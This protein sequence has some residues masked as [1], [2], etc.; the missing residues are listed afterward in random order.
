VVAGAATPA[1]ATGSVFY[2][3]A[4]GAIDSGANSCAPTSNPGADGCDLTAALTNAGSGDT[5]YLATPGSA[6]SYYGNWTVSGTSPLTIEALTPGSDQPIL[7]GDA[8]A[9]AT[10]QTAACDSSILSLAAGVDLTINSVE[11]TDSD[12]TATSMGGA[13]DNADGTLVVT[14]CTFDDNTSDS[15][16]GA[17]DNADNGGAGSLDVFGSTFNDNTADGDGGAIDNADYGGE[18]TAT[19]SDSTFTANTADGSDGGAI[20]NGDDNS[21]SGTLTVT[22][23]TFSGDNSN[24]SGAAIANGDFN[25]D[26]TAWVAGDVFNET[27]GQADVVAGTSVWNDEGYNSGVGSSC[28]SSTPAT[29]DSPVANSGDLGLGSLS[30]NGGPT[31]TMSVGFLTPPFESVPPNTTVT[32]NSDTVSLCS[33]VDQ[34]G[35]GSIPGYPCNEGALNL[36]GELYAYADGSDDATDCSQNAVPTCSLTDALSRAAGAP[37]QAA[38][39]IYLAT[40]GTSEHYVGNWDVNVPHTTSEGLLHIE[41]A[42]G[43]ASAP[44]LDGNQ[45]NSSG[46]TTPTCNGAI[47]EI[48]AN[49]NVYIKGITFTDAYNKTSQDGGAIDDGNGNAGGQLTIDTDT[50]T[51][52][53]AGSEGGAIDLADNGGTVGAEIFSSTFTDNNAASGG[54]IGAGVAGGNAITYITGSTFNGNHTNIGSGGAIDNGSNGTGQLNVAQSTFYDNSAFGGGAIDTGDHGT[55]TLTVTGTTF[56]DNSGTDGDSIDSADE[57]GAGSVGVAGDLF[58]GGCDL[59]A[60][61]TFTDNGY[62]AGTDGSCES[63]G[64]ADVTSASVSLLGTLEDHGGPTE[65]M[66]PAWHNPAIGV[67]PNPTTALCP[68]TDQDGHFTA[69]AQACNAGSVDSSTAPP[70]PGSPGDGGPTPGAPTVNVTGSPNPSTYG[71]GSPFTATI[72]GGASCG[73]VQW[74]VDGTP[75]GSPVSVTT[76]TTGTNGTTLTFTPPT[77]LSAGS[78]QVQAV[79]TPCSGNPVTGSVTEVV[80]KAGTTLTITVSGGTATATVKPVAPGAGTPTGTVTFTVNGQTQPAVTLSGGVATLT[81]P[82]TPATASAGAAPATPVVTA[83]YSGDANFTGSSGT[84][85]TNVT[86]PT[87]TAKVTSAHAKT[88]YGWYRSP[89]KIT[90]TCT[91]GSSALSAA[92]PSPVTL[93]GNG[94]A[95]SVTKTI[96][97]SDGGTATAVVSPINIDHTTPSVTVGGVKSGH[98]YSKTRTLTCHASDKLSGIAHCT[99]HKTHTSHN[100]TI[101]VHYTASAKDKAGNVTTK[102]GDYLIRG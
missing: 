46:C 70:A 74:L 14:D 99:I 45:G 24:T 36:P 54:A 2:A 42:P 72:G 62:N 43:L 44:V 29:T 69:S 28:F 11:L 86:D 93:S 81:L 35:V 87:I 55:G 102:K 68:R 40:A 57:S 15:D 59:G 51:S 85:A 47:L 30:D 31:Q 63:G 84:S 8:T 1:A 25:G 73:T 23:S 9:N 6:G 33:R 97:A 91:A 88:K 58:D 48:A 26:G 61:G 18:G 5:I 21:S 19:V 92:C 64:T 32:V 67:V 53:E 38:D 98:T 83:A 79:F 27:C 34:R 71:Q 80:N 22:D 66:W 7:D 39:T 95:Q 4:N 65:T 82:A 78:H 41:P 12:N 75:S 3:Y 96:T 50:F 89:V 16:G 37:P 77:P 60:G 94:A 56:A 52:N 100:G 90:F 20:D 10:C 76:G 17:I 101:T 13:V 49:Q